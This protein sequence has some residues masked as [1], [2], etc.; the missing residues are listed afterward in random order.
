LLNAQG[1][2]VGVIQSRLNPLGRGQD[3]MIP[4]NVNFAVSLQQL[5]AMMRASAMSAILGDA[6][7]PSSDGRAVGMV[8][9][10]MTGQVLCYQNK[11]EARLNSR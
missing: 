4:Q 10:N 9:Q 5:Q 3:V 7:D 2:V 6:S 1:H 11:L 8:A